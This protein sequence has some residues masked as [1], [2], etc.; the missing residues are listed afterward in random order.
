MYGISRR[1]YADK[2]FPYPLSRCWQNISQKKEIFKVLWLHRFLPNK[3]ASLAGSTALSQGS[4]WTG[5]KKKL[6]AV[7]KQTWSKPRTL[8]S[9][10][11]G[12]YSQTQGNW[13]LI[14]KISKSCSTE[15]CTIS[16]QI[17]S[18]NYV[19]LSAKVWSS[20]RK[21]KLEYHLIP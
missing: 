14:R 9:Q 10:L 18:M 3:Q 16:L 21:N 1:T 17:W 13:T 2:C 4:A 12:S 8:N 20:C 11:E 5:L 6:W 7:F 19:L 15:S